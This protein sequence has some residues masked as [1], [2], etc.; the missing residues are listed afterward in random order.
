MRC[1]WWKKRRREDGSKVGR[2][3]G[4]NEES[5][6]VEEIRGAKSGMKKEDRGP[7]CFPSKPNPLSKVTTVPSCS[8]KII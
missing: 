8:T 2:K 7:V 3:G 1:R 6:E 4:T 5:R